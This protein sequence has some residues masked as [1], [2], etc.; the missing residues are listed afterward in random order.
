MRCS[1]FH[2]G[3]DNYKMLQKQVNL[4][5]KSLHQCLLLN[6]ILL[7][8]D[9]TELIYFHKAGSKITTDIS[10]KLNGKKLLHS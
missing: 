1:T 8:K 6:K 10:I 7:N 5:L 4:D 2:F 3:N 9:K